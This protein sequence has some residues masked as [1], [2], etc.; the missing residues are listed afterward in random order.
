M[1]RI[2]I[3]L[4]CIVC[5]GANSKAAKNVEFKSSGFS[6]TIT[7]N[8]MIRNLK[9][10]DNIIIRVMMLHGNYKPAHG[11]EKHDQRFF[12]SYERSPAKI[13]RPDEKNMLVE[14]KTITMGNKKYPKALIYSEKITLSPD[15][16]TVDYEVEIKETMGSNAAFLM[17]LCELPLSLSGRG[18]KVVNS[19]GKETMGI[20][21]P[22]Y[23][24]KNKIN[25]FAKELAFSLPEGLVTITAGENS[26]LYF[27]DSR[28][29]KGDHLRL[30]ISQAIP[31]KSKVTFYKAGTKFKWSFTISIKKLN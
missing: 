6:A 3:T 5:L 1:S 2:I 8:G 28:S 31:W 26:K 30:D 4:L 10:A 14:K 25:Y 22:K 24:P 15:K 12:Q 13:T 19:L 29:W 23:D 27:T 21:S 18:F 16:I 17:T 7:R 9:V 20:I 11:V